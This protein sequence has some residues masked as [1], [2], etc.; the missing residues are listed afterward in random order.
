MKKRRTLIGQQESNMINARLKP[1]IDSLIS[2]IDDDTGESL[3]R[4]KEA[5]FVK[6]IKNAIDIGMLKSSNPRVRAALAK[7]TR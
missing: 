7:A 3:T 2:G 5:T 6:D 1:A 4:A